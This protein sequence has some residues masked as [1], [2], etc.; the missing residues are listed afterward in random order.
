MEPHQGTKLRVLFISSQWTL[1]VLAWSPTIERGART[2]ATKHN[3]LVQMHLLYVI[4]LCQFSFVLGY[5]KHE[6]TYVGLCVGQGG[7]ALIWHIY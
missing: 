5:L 3:M 7:H 2:V 6:S 4:T 1:Y